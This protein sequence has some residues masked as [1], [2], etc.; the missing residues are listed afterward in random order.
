MAVV[1]ERFGIVMINPKTLGFSTCP[2]VLAIDDEEVMGYLIKRIVRNLGYSVEWVTNCETALKR[3]EEQHF[4]VILS[5]FKM[6]NMTGDQ[7]YCRLAAIDREILGRLVFI[8]GDT[9]NSKT[10][11]FLTNNAI[12]YL[13]KPFKICELEIAIQNIVNEQNA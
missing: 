10:L 8:T 7:F 4:D 2:R 13:S 9:V 6:P 12:P 3:I 1:P 5:D 11:R